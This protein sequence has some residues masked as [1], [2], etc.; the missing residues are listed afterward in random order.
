MFVYRRAVRFAEVDAARLV[1]FS[2]YV[3]YCHDAMEA[4]F[5][6]LP[7]GYEDF[8][9][10]RDL[11]LPT[12]RLEIEYRAPLR[13]GDVARLETDVLRVG[14]T[15]ITLRHRI[16]RDADDALVTVVEQVVVVTRLSTLVP[17]PV[18]DDVRGLFDAHLVPE[19]A[20]RS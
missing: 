10:R 17:Q 12:V 7:G 5:A 15:S 9:M 6:A 13:Y 16:W 4:L 18:P 1:F 8:T 20:A 3:E 14:R 19:G 11:G 2:R